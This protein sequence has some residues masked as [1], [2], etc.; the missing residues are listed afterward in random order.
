VAVDG[1][2][3][4]TSRELSR[5]VAEAGVGKKVEIALLRDGKKK[6]IGVALAKY[7]TQEPTM[8]QGESRSDDLG[9]QVRG[10]DPEI[11]DRLG[12]DQD[13]QGVVVTQVDPDSKSA[14][15]G[16]QEGDLVI[17]INR[18]PVKSLEDYNAL[19]A[20][21]DKG[22]TVSMLLRRGP[23]GMLAVKFKR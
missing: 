2:A 16:I 3:V 14:E 8:A 10:L 21:I 5:M 9:M 20:K 7:P 19:I 11:A 23:G 15:A 6:T 22:D 13:Q 12:L 4:K 18:N 17:E 1:K